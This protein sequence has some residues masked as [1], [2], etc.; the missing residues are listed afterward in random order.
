MLKGV[1]RINSV[2]V[3]GGS[4][5]RNN[6]LGSIMLVHELCVH[7][8]AYV[9]VFAYLYLCI[10]SYVSLSHVMISMCCKRLWKRIYYT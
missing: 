6:K 8:G 3:L 1:G 7:G 9:V 5:I 2:G 10:I 4:I